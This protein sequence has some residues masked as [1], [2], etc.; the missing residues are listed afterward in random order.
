VFCVN[1]GA[2]MQAWASQQD[3]DEAD[4]FITFMADPAGELTDMLNIKLDHP[5]PQAK[6]L[7]GRC[8]RTAIYL[9]DGVVRL[10]KVAEKT[11]DPAG[12]DFPE[13]T[14]ATAMIDAI[15]GLR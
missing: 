1:D 9:E 14:C 11:G 10:F 6:G 7:H 15:Q 5:G 2:V 8:K 12:D 3:I 13:V 4:G